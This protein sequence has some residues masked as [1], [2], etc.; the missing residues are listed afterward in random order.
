MHRNLFIKIADQGTS[1]SYYGGM[2]FANKAAA[3]ELKAIN[4]L[5]KCANTSMLHFPLLA[6]VSPIFF[7]FSSSYLLCFSGASAW[8]SFDCC[9]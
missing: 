4:A 9:L 7:F 8:S 2:H 5:L 3:H 6:L 1:L